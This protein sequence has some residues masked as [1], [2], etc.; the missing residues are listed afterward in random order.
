MPDKTDN[1]GTRRS[2]AADG[3]LQRWRMDEI[4]LTVEISA[5]G[6]INLIGSATVTVTGGIKVT[7][8]RQA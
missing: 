8:K 5:E 6:G 4:Q 2:P 7:F 3:T 1:S